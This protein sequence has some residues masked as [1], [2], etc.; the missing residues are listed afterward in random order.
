MHMYM[1]TSGNA[2]AKALSRLTRSLSRIGCVLTVEGTCMREALD[3]L[4]IEPRASRMLS[5]CDTARS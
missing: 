4:G 1:C 2:C 3:T 5:G